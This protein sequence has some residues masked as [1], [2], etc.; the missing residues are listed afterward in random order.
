M[1]K[2]M[3]SSN[4]RDAHM[5]LKAAKQAILDMFAYHEENNIELSRA[6]IGYMH[7]EIEQINEMMEA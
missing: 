1:N 5:Q 7:S 4:T 6:S 3:I 2:Y